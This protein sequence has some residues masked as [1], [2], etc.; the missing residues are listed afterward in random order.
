[1]VEE[2]EPLAANVR[3]AL[4]TSFMV[5]ATLFPADLEFKGI[6]HLIIV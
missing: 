4:L 6:S 3:F 5:S 2:A 1:M